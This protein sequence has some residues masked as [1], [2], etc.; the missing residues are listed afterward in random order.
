MKKKVILAI[1][2]VLLLITIIGAY[3]IYWSN[4]HTKEKGVEGLLSYIKGNGSNL[5]IDDWEYSYK[6][7]EEDYF[8]LGSGMVMSAMDASASSSG[9]ISSA[10]SENSKSYVSSESTIGLSTGGAK[11]IENFRENIKNGY[12]PISTDITYNGLFYDYYFNTGDSNSDKNS[13]DLFYPSYSTAISKDPI[14]GVPEYYMTVGLNSNI[15][16]SD[17]ARKKLNLV[18]VMDISGS[19]SSGFNSYYYDGNNSNKEEYKSKM[20]I[21]N[22]SLNLLLDELEPEDRVG[23]VLFDNNAYLAKPV[24]MVGDTNIEA[25]K[26]HILEITPQG[27]TNFE[28][29][30]TKGTELF[31]KEMLDDSEYENR[32][33]VI[34]DAMPNMGTTS[35]NDLA[36][37]IKENADN[38]IYTTFIGVGVDFNTEVIETLSDVKGAN[39]Y[40]VHSSEEFKKIM[41]EDFD[42]M[43]TPLVFDLELKLDST[44][45]IIKNVYGTDTK[46]KTTGTL[47]KV[48]TLFPSSR[49]ESGEAKGGIILLKVAPAIIDFKEEPEFE[50]TQITVS[51][52][53]RDGKEHVNKQ[54]VKFKTEFIKDGEYISTSSNEYYDNTGIRKGI[55]LTRYVNLM[56]NWILFERGEE[57]RNFVIDAYTGIKDCEYTKEQIVVM[58]GENERSSVK[59]SVSDEYS[60]NFKN[61]KEYFEKEMEEI[62]DDEMKQ[63]VEILD[64]LIK[65]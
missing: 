52:K 55:A 43:V 3:L 61:F 1:V 31:S 23:I 57:N 20:K 50:G 40:S 54:E 42:Y 17:F 24:N 18:I 12:F 14:S 16:E 33:I 47:M 13:N 25:I 22:E 62:G 51:Y 9:G 35:R 41:S 60:K 30:Y 19:M 65:K 28:A 63:E 58:L 59:L 15:K 39:Y 48:N 44:E 10:F 29:G 27:G 21:A 4:T 7:Y 64:M 11:N 2:V 45:Y 36:K 26:K 53:D 49:N 6:N 38:K 34:T 32:I 46:E 5:L 56:K 8:G 37:Y